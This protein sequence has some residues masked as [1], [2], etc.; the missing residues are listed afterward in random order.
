MIAVQGAAKRPAGASSSGP[1]PGTVVG[2]RLAQP[3]IDLGKSAEE[4][5]WPI[6]GIVGNTAHLKKTGDHTPWSKGK[7]PGVIYAIDVHPPNGF[8]AWLIAQCRSS[9]DTRWIDFFNINGSQYNAAGV[10]VAPSTDTHLHISVAKGYEDTHVTL[11]RDYAG[12]DEDDMPTAKEVAQA[13]WGAAL[14]SPTLD[15]GRVHG[16][17]EGVICAIA[18][19]RALKGLTET[20]NGLVTTVNTL[21]A[22]VDRLPGT[23]R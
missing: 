5:G 20:V 16:A 19:V 15:E 3:I 6:L 2:W 22:A 13:V 21:Q 1:K 14:S 7:R 12:G 4:L 8:Q 11:F 18:T 9:Y 10:R 23:A 17:H